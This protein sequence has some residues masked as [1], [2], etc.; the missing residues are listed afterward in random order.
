[1][2]R[3]LCGRTGG[4]VLA[5][6]ALAACALFGAARA[7][8]ERVVDD[9]VFRVLDGPLG[10]DARITTQPVTLEDGTSVDFEVS[11]HQVFAPVAQIVVHG[12]F[13]DT[14]A[15]P[16]TDRWFT[17]RVVGD[18]SSVV[19]LARGRSLR[20]FVVT[21]G[22]VSVLGPER[23]P[24]GDGPPGR[25]LVRTLDPETDVP[26]AMRTFTCGTD[27]LPVPPETKP[28]ASLNRRALSNVMYY[29]GIAVETD[30]ELYA[31]FNSTVNLTKYVGDLFAFVSAVYQRD[32][33]VTLQV[34]YLSIWTTAADPWNATSGT[35][36][37]L[38]E[39]VTYWS[40]NRT[41]IPRATA[42]MLSGKGLGGG[43][44]YLNALCG[45]A[46]Y[47]VSASLSGVAPT[48]ISTTYWDFMVV[49]HE[50]GHNFGSPH[51]HCYSPPVDQCWASESGCYSGPT[52]VPPEK[53]TI[54]SYCHQLS[55]GYSNIK[56][57]L[58]V[59]GET[60]QAVTARIRTY[61]EGRPT[62]FG[63]V[64]GPV[65]T[66]I[67]PNSG[68]AAGGT[69]VTISGTGFV[70]GATVTIGGVAATGVAFVNATTL[71]ATTGAHADGI[72]EVTVK[73][74]SN[75]GATAVGLYTYGTGVPPT[76][77]PTPT[78]TA[79]RTSTPTITPTLTPTA[80]ATPIQTPTFLPGTPTPTPTATRTPAP[81]T[82]PPPPPPTPTPTPTVTPTRTPTPTPLGATTFFALTPCRLVDTRNVAGPLG[83]PALGGAASRTFTL[84]GSCGV[85]AGT[86]TV[87]ANVTIVSPAAAGDLV[88]YPA[89]LVSPPAVSTVSFRAGTTRANNAHLFLSGDGTGRVTVRNNTNGSLNLVVDVNGYYR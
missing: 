73:N 77:T 1:M 89:T 85:P 37:A 50:L 26:D 48:N 71:T 7:D 39:F 31:K 42:H 24:Y 25:T 64:D 34:N 30:Y 33:L 80:T 47:G 49:A 32:V 40:T 52:S 60:S 22:R 61:V 54:M 66:G 4:R 9:R 76:P 69:A 65:V 45:G 74:P 27:S 36:A 75:Q 58:G 79:T 12:R 43:I 15:P 53:G 51:T 88:I 41:T 78:A 82:P 6:I 87:S 11:Q 63:T 14:L 20:G 35:S 5:A 21:G 29:A 13:G 57:F 67:S 23:H 70:S 56:M 19:V 55:G 62:C 86:Q 17:G 38:S 72:V 68:P 16:P 46:G 28:A 81:T 8:A 2:N 59:P 3:V 83:G 18:P 10:P 84:I 44:A